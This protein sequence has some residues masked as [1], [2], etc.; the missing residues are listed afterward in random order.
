[1]NHRY[2]FL[3]DI[4]EKCIPARTYF[5]SHSMNLKPIQSANS[6]QLLSLARFPL[7]FPWLSSSTLLFYPPAPAIKGWNESL[8]HI[9]RQE[10]TDNSFLPLHFISRILW[11]FPSFA[12]TSLCWLGLGFTRCFYFFS[13]AVLKRKPGSLKSARSRGIV[14]GEKKSEIL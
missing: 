2:I 10:H 7:F 5:L 1:M 13:W 12:P 11:F 8:M 6:N 14:N 3:R 4:P 9:K